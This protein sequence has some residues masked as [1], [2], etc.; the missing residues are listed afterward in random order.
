MCVPCALQRQAFNHPFFQYQLELMLT[1]GIFFFEVLFGT[2]FETNKMFLQELKRDKCRHSKRIRLSGLQTLCVRVTTT[3]IVVYFLEF[4]CFE[5][6]IGCLF[7]FGKTTTNLTVCI[8]FSLFLQCQH[9]SEEGCGGHGLTS[10]ACIRKLL[11]FS[12]LGSVCV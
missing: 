4:L 2:C 3:R 8:S 11:S 6:E 10:S 5:T 12:L 1:C 7:V 9:V